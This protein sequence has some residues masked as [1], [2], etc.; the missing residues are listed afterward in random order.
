MGP[1]APHVNSVPQTAC[2]PNGKRIC[3]LLPLTQRI[4]EDHVQEQR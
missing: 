1:Q 3:V 2:L 4:L